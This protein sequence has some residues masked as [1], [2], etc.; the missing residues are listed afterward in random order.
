L[1]AHSSFTFIESATILAIVVLCGMG[2]QMGVVVSALILIG[3]IELF[4]DLDLYR[5]L[6]FGLA[7]VAIMVSR[8]HGLVASREPSIALKARKAIGSD[9]HG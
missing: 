6:I 3:G 2:S 1:A 9:G 7:M 4:R 8:P 5:M